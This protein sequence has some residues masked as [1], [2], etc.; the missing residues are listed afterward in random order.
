[1][2]EQVAGRPAKI[3]HVPRAMLRVMSPVL[4]PFHPGLSQSMAF[5]LH[6]DLHDTTYDA[7]LLLR[8]YPLQL[9]RLEDWIA[10]HCAATAAARTGSAE[11]VA[12]AGAA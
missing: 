1:M 8:R 4:R 7:A 9:T 6:D 10:E 2:F 12:P 5:A 3:S 11:S